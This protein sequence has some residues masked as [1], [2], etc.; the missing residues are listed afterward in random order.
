MVYGYPK[1]RIGVNINKSKCI[2]NPKKLA[3]M[4]VFIEVYCKKSLPRI[5]QREGFWF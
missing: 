2:N 1:N 3:L 4:K 5:P